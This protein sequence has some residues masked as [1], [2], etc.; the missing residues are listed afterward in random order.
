M[1]PFEGTRPKNRKGRA[2]M[3]HQI[4]MKSNA[5]TELLL[6]RVLE[7]SLGGGSPIPPL[8]QG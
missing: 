7:R 2:V 1:S 3:G 8:R 4:R 5:E 6:A